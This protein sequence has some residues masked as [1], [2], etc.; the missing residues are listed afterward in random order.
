MDGSLWYVMYRCVVSLCGV[1]VSLCGVGVS[2][3]GVGV[4]LCG[5]GVSLCGVGVSLCGSLW[6]V[7][8]VYHYDVSLCGSLWFV[9]YR[10]V[11]HYGISNDH[12]PRMPTV[13]VVT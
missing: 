8:S 5:V 13:D 3:C 4:S 11:D 6:F 9:V 10:C 7:M 2:L 1:G 12:A